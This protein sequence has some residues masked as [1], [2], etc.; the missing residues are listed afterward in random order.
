VS[1]LIDFPANFLRKCYQIKQVEWKSIKGD[2][3]A[4]GNSIYAG[5]FPSL[6]CQTIE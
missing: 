5:S 6:I 2:L 1:V 3:K 4:E